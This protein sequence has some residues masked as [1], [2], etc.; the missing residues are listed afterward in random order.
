MVL[1]TILHEQMIEKISFEVRPKTGKKQIFDHLAPW[2]VKKNCTTYSDKVCFVIL[3]KNENMGLITIENS[4]FI[5]A[6][7]Y[8]RQDTDLDHLTV[9]ESP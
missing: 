7:A 6:W 8:I 9:E 3:T 5:S 4:Y 2:G 1:K